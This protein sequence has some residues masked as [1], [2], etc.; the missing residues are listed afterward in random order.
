M[1]AIAP[2]FAAA[3][4]SQASSNA[5]TLSIAGSPTSSG[6]VN[7]TN[8]GTDESKTGETNPI[9]GV[10][11][12]QSLLNVGV[13]AQEAQAK[14]ASNGDGVSA[15]CGGIAGEGAGFAANVG[16]SNC[17]TPGDPVGLSIAN[18][19]LTGA[20]AIDPT[21]AIGGLSAL[22]PFLA[23][24]LGPVT[25]AISGA[26]APLGNT[27]LGGTLGAVYAHCTA[28]PGTAEGAAN[29]VDSKLTLSVAGTDI[30][31]VNLPANPPPNTHVLTDLDAVLNAV[32]DGVQTDLNTT[33]DGLAQPLAGIVDTVQ[34]QLVDTLVAQV[35]DALSPLEDN[36]LDITLNKQTKTSDTIE[37]TALDLQ[38]L[39]AAAQFTGSSLVAAQIGTVTCGPNGKKTVS[40][41]T[42][43]DD[44]T[45][46]VPTVVDS[47]VSGQGSDT[48]RNVLVATGALMALAGTAGL[49]GY[50]RMLVK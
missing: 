15:A 47:G 46:S 18:L 17:L 16:D 19:D 12:G 24:L 50:R 21:S 37:I 44:P 10:L 22:N 4:V 13:L 39:P 34:T 38:L 25:N 6:T 41:P 14:V 20:T 27:G 32:L 23:Q 43:T 29:I 3:P 31:L 49:I 28:A 26:L 35:A 1:L 36:I 40:E 9:V 8:D 5:L 48:A 2:V 45:P 7:A 30:D 33:L 42:P 11:G